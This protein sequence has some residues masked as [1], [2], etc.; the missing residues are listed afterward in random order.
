MTID[1][2]N[3]LERFNADTNE[4]WVHSSRNGQLVFYS[5]I[6]SR[7]LRSEITNAIR[8]AEKHAEQ[9]TMILM[10]LHLDKFTSSS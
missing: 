10:K 9:K 2:K 7:K 5:K 4:F 3:M 1:C 8:Q 6:K